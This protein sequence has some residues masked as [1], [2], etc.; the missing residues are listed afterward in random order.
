L[1]LLHT[2]RR[3]FPAWGVVS[4]FSEERRPR[5]QHGESVCSSLLAW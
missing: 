2:F 5:W 4:A 3:L 1:G